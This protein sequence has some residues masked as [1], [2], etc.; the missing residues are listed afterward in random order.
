MGGCIDPS[1]KRSEAKPGDCNLRASVSYAGRIDARPDHIPVLLDEVLD[2]LDPQ[3]GQTLADGTLGLGG[4]ALAIA[5][6]LG[7][8]GQVIGIDLD[9]GNLVQVRSRFESEGAEVAALETLHDNFVRMPQLL[10][11][12]GN[13]ANMVLVDLG[14]SS[15]Q[16]DD[17]SRG[18]SFRADGPL[19]MRLDPSAPASAADL[20]ASLAEDEL[21]KIIFEYG[22]EPLA[23]KIARF[24]VR[25]RRV[26]P[27]QS[28]LQ[29]ARL[30]KEAYGARARDSRM[31]PATRTFMAL[32]I[33]VNDELAA[34]Q[35]LLDQVIAAA[36]G[37]SAP[38]WLAADARIAVISFH[39]LEDRRVKQAF[40][41]LG[42][43]GLV[44]VLTPKPRVAGE[45]ELRENPRSRSAKLRAVRMAAHM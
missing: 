9:P 36:S 10:R 31:H 3:P 20:I 6:R 33:A 7:S 34:L 32:R 35:G 19:D 1:W 21:G 45:K 26:E 15:S 39:S 14:F 8:A 17:P 41:Q 24:L 18:L 37:P 13:I 27:I 44:T 28:T 25:R 42:R 30:V 16:M 43:E 4:H 38:S 12:G 23:R 5:K 11:D 40:A 29:L 2:L 22:E